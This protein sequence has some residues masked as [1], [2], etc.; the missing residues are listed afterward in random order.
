MLSDKML[1]HCLHL[2]LTNLWLLT[3][4]LQIRQPNNEIERK[5]SA[6]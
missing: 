3:T 6:K 5:V 2:L 1:H 4:N